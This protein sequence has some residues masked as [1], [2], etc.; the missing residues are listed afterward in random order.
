MSWADACY[1][2]LLY[3]NLDCDKNVLS[4]MACSTYA[5]A[6]VQDTMRTEEILD[7]SEGGGSGN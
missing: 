5:L 4:A 1:Y 7:P 6:T 2:S 3:S